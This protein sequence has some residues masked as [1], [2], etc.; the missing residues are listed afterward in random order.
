MSGKM[1][2]SLTCLRKKENFLYGW[3]MVIGG[4]DIGSDQ[5]CDILWARER[6]FEFT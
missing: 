5:I 6:G 2:I 3:V 4:T 1:G